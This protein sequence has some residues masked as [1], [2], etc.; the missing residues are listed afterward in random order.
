M[1]AISPGPKHVTPGDVHEPSGALLKWYAVHLQDRPVPDEITRLARSYLMKN[2]RE[3]KGLGFV[4]FHRCGNDFYFLIVS[5]WRNNNQV[6]ESVFYKD[7]E[8]MTDFALW[9]REAVHKPTHCVWEPVPLWHEQKAWERFLKSSRDLA[10][11]KWGSRIATPGR[12]E[13]SI[14]SVESYPTRMR[15]RL[16]FLIS[17]ALTVMGAA[18]A[19]IPW[20]P[21]FLNF[22]ASRCSSL[23]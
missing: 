2:N 16:V 17:L 23:S 22:K 19:V 21:S 13:M 12:R 14:E 5:T 4:I 15:Q 7:G 18:A 1:P 3:A 20:L 9:P 8:A 6:W 11:R 10:Q